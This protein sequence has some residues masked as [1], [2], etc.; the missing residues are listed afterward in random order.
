MARLAPFAVR[1]MTVVQL[2]LVPD[3]FFTFYYWSRAV[4]LVLRILPSTQGQIS[5]PS[6]DTWRVASARGG[7]RT[8]SAFAFAHLQLH[9]TQLEEAVTFFITAA[10]LLL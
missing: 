6:R 1:A 10:S 3:F 2:V 7:A 5:G 4:V 8:R 9:A